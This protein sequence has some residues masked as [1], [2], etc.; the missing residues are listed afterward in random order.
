MR[1][2]NTY[3]F[4]IINYTGFHIWLPRSSMMNEMVERLASYTQPISLTF[5]KQDLL[6]EGDLAPISRLTHL[7]YLKFHN[8]WL[9]DSCLQFSTLTNLEFFSPGTTFDNYPLEVLHTFTKLRELSTWRLNISFDKLAKVFEKLPNLENIRLIVEASDEIGIISK[10]PTEKLTS[11]EVNFMAYQFV[12][13]ADVGARFTNLKTL[14]WQNDT[15]VVFP[16]SKLTNLVSLKCSSGGHLQQLGPLTGLTQLTLWNVSKDAS[17]DHL[18]ALTNLASVEIEMPNGQPQLDFFR[19][20]PKLSSCSIS[21]QLTGDSLTVIP[22]ERMTAL[23]VT[24]F[25]GDSFD[26]GELARFSNL[27]RFDGAAKLGPNLKVALKNLTRL[28]HANIHVW[29]EPLGDLDMS[30]LVQLE[31]LSLSNTTAHVAQSLAPL[32]NLTSLKMPLKDHSDFSFLAHKPLRLLDLD[33]VD[34]P[35][36]WPA[37]A[38]L[39]ALETLRLILVDSGDEKIALLSGLTRLTALT[40]M[41]RITGE[42]LTCLTSLQYLD[43]TTVE[44]Q[45]F[46][47][48]K[49][50]LTPFLPNLLTEPGN[51]R[52]SAWRG[53]TFKTN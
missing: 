16:V 26:S 1:L 35:A 11:L 17:T 42:R 37:L 15:N 36:L 28:T 5:S 50:Q 20:L 3:W 47:T 8:T 2:A 13:S 44:S 24:N 48:Q 23:S 52:L 31:H 40:L 12:F 45:R 14:V 25:N 43:F 46:Y 9:T 21:G 18:A 29:P 30:A 38:T 10:I 51:A 33:M 49:S 4:K 19:S 53:Q 32:T 27:Q 39:S 41:G 7:T 6:T 34:A 22:H